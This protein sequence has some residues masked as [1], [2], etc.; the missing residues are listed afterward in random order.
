MS[1]RNTLLTSSPNDRTRFFRADSPSRGGQPRST[2]STP[3]WTMR[4]RKLS[5]SSA[6]PMEI[7]GRERPAAPCAA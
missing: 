3:S 4:R 5:D 6:D 1:G 2:Q 7:R